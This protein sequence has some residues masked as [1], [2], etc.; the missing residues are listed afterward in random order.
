MISLSTE[1]YVIQ[2]SSLCSISTM[3]AFFAKWGKNK[4]ILSKL[5]I[6]KNI[7]YKICYYPTQAGREISF[8]LKFLLFKNFLLQD[9][10]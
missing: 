8:L 6:C 2:I 4:L 10:L 1:F 5:N 9:A 3:I 7:L